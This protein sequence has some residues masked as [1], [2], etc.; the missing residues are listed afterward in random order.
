M[1]AQSGR[2][3]HQ[4]FCPGH[5]RARRIAAMPGGLMIKIHG[6]AVAS[7]QAAERFGD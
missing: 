1:A 6:A 7:G 4:D 5:R 2:N 3:A